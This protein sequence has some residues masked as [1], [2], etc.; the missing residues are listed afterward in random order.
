MNESCFALG[1]CIQQQCAEQFGE[2]HTRDIK[3]IQE[4][5][6]EELM[7]CENKKEGWKYEKQSE[8]GNRTW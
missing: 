7:S 2:K 6:R 8:K 3:A 5:W 4:Y 1:R